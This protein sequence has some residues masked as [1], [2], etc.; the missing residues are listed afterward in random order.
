M[1]VNPIE[2]RRQKYFQLSSQIAQLDN[3]RLHSLFDE[4][5]SNPASSGWGLNHV[6]LLGES[7]VFV[8]RIPV[9]NIEYDNLLST[10]NLY[11]LPTYCNYGIGLIASTG[12]GIF[13]EL[14]THIKTTNWVLEGAIAT[15]PLMY[16][17]RIIPFS[18]QRADV[19]MEQHKAYVEYWGNSENIGNYVLDRAIANYELVLFLEHIPYVLETWLHENPNKLQN[20]LDDLLRTIDFLRMKGIIHFDAHFRNVLTDGEQIYLTDFGLVLDKSFALTKDEETFFD[21][22]KFYDYGEVMRNLGHLI[23]PSYDSCSE[24]EKSRIMEKYGI[25]EGLQPYEVRAILLDNIEQIQADEDMKLDE[26]YVASIVKYRSIIALMQDFFV[27]LWGNNKKDT[28]FDGAKLGLLLEKTGSIS[29]SIGR[30]P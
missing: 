22:H 11:N 2:L 27:E 13:R 18:G 28:K 30:S 12:L 3:A 15:F 19:D 7:K 17:Y 26:F 8:K 14:V 24:S 23:R 6:I 21:R 20:S 29:Q 25:K 10:K 9:T 16:H 5:E 4:S 1:A